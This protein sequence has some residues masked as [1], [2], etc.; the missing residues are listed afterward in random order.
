M[1]FNFIRYAE[2]IASELVAVSHTK[3]RKRFFRAFGIEDLYNLDDQ[4]TSITSPVLIAVDA[5]ET[6]SRPV[7]F[8]CLVDTRSYTIIIAE[9]T[10][11]TKPETIDLAADHCHQ[12]CIEVRNRMLCD[13][14]IRPNISDIH[15]MGVGPI[16]ENLYG[17]ALTF[18]I[19][20]SPAT[21]CT[22]PNQWKEAE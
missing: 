10:S 15:T 3:Q 21:F 4:L 16:G 13:A 22:D 1:N 18:T 14:E 20:E 2:L 7:S 8:D 17:C 19:D 11:T 12:L 5:R 9:P 6:D